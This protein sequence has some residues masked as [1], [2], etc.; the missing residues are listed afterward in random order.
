MDLFE[1]GQAAHS[2]KT[3]KLIGV[4]NWSAQGLLLLK[5][6]EQTLNL[7]PDWRMIGVLLVLIGLLVNFEVR[8]I[9]SEEEKEL[10]GQE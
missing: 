8:V 3:P 4:F 9:S 7:S 2:F 6:M 5:A 10:K 1:T